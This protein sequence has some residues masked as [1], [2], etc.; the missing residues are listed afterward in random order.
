MITVSV[1]VAVLLTSGVL[2]TLPPHR[3][4]TTKFFPFPQENQEFSFPSDISRTFRIF[5]SV[6]SFFSFSLFAFLGGDFLEFSPALFQDYFPEICAGL[7]A[8][9]LLEKLFF[10]LRRPSFPAPQNGFFSFFSFFSA[11]FLSSLPSK[12]MSSFLFCLE[13]FSVRLVF[14]PF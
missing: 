12:T 7:F 14:L 3:F 1:F 6:F 11:A 8:I 9:V 13:F 4:F 5:T 10:A 2:R